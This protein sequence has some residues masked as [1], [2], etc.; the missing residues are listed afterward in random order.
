MLQSLDRVK[1]YRITDMVPKDF[2]SIT[3]HVKNNL[4]GTQ[5]KKI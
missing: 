5:S 3:G 4:G 1:I 2:A